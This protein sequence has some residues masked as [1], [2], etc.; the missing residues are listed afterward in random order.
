MPP[1]PA[2]AP[3][4]C[5][6]LGLALIALV[7]GTP[8]AFAQ[9][10][11][12]EAPPVEV[13]APEAPDADASPPAASPTPDV[14]PP[15]QPEAEERAVQARRHFDT[16]VKLFRDEN[17]KGALAEFEATY[18][19]SPS[20]G[21]LRNVALC[22]KALWR[23][24]EASDA[25]EQLL[26]KHGAQLSATERKAIEDAIAELATLVGRLTIAV[27]PATAD[28]TVDGQPVTEEERTSG[29]RLNTGEHT[30][31]ATAPGYAQLIRVIR[32]AGGEV[33]HQD[34]GLKATMGFVTVVT[35][36]PDAAIAI[37][38]EAKAFSQWSGPVKP[39]RR[40][41][42][43]YK[44]GFTPFEARVKV[45]LG[46]TVQVNATLG[47]PT[48][49]TSG[50]IKLNAPPPPPGS[51][52]FMQQGWY[53]LGS[54]TLL[55]VSDAPD[56]LDHDVQA[57]DTE[58]GGASTG[59]RAGYRLWNPLAVEALIEGGGFPVTK[60]CDDHNDWAP[61]GE[62]QVS[63]DYTLTTVRLG[64]NV[65][66]LSGGE[67]L[68]F[69]STLGTGSVRHQ[70]DVPALTASELDAIAVEY[71][72]TND[73][74]TAAV[75]ARDIEPDREAAGW[76]PYF[77]LE[78]GLQMNLKHA[79]FEGNGTVF[80]DGTGNTR[81]DGY[82]PYRGLVFVG[83]GLRAGWSEWAPRPGAK[84]RAAAPPQ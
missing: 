61:C 8:S 36:D 70:L 72:R 78:V 83:L 27:L 3:R 32:V 62:S 29:L 54:L 46:Q 19:L 28:V 15:Q 52:F 34:L 22:S 17:Y 53:A 56:G 24:A 49:D 42:Q 7:G 16:G 41:V 63:R 39:G 25:L 26:E 6:A 13:S 69:T 73:A 67:K 4:R 74:V 10:A 66:L 2:P 58:I 11:A 30:V 76:N 5:P 18:E 64:G 81:G 1:P 21:A 9:P 38:G 23:Y 82:E 37:D 75:V 45:D 65:R 20:A 35:G 51:R 48:G 14:P 47:P 33:S 60:A 84:L 12:P 50:T 40:L 68:R 31:V 55:G 79:L 43:V 71:G 77:M 59:V 80:I 44:D 57:G